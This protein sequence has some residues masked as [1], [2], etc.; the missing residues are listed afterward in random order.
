MSSYSID[1]KYVKVCMS[2]RTARELKYSNFGGIFNALV[3]YEIVMDVT[4]YI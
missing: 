3:G 4:S 1:H 2:A